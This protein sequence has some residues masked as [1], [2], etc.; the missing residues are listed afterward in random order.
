LRCAHP[1][2]VKTRLSTGDIK[3]KRFS[4]DNQRLRHRRRGLVSNGARSRFALCGDRNCGEM[5]AAAARCRRKNAAA[6]VR[7]IGRW[8]HQE[9]LR[10][11][12]DWRVARV[13]LRGVGA[14]TRA[15]SPHG[16]DE[17]RNG[18][19]ERRLRISALLGGAHG[20]TGDI[21]AR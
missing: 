6:A 1:P 14:R 4:G 10:A 7:G 13:T 16:S 18:W 17:R 19:L 2:R 12:G 11:A 9:H 15:S 5:L 20:W 8:R 21:A 3:S